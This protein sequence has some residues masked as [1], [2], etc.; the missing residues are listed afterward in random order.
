MAPKAL[1]RLPEVSDP[2]L[3]HPLRTENPRSAVDLV[4]FNVAS[5]KASKSEIREAAA[6]GY[7]RL[8]QV[9]EACRRW[10]I[11]PSH[12]VSKTEIGRELRIG[13]HRNLLHIVNFVETILLLSE[14]LMILGNE[15]VVPCSYP[16]CIATNG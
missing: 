5:I 1:R 15:T 6:D 12:I 10:E 13:L 3:M 2:F 11:L 8:I 16:M 7:A 14:G 9:G 4:S